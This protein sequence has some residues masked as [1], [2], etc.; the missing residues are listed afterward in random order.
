MTDEHRDLIAHI[1]YWRTQGRSAQAIAD[2]LNGDGVLAPRGGAWQKGTVL[3]IAKR[4][5]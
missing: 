4:G 5:L 1:V 3:K 2:G